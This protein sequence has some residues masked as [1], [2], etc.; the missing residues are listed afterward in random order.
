[1]AV[2]INSGLI[3]E[4]IREGSGSVDDFVVHWEER[5]VSGRQRV[6]RSRD[7]STIYRWLERG[8]PSNKDDVFGFAAAL[9]VDPVGIL[10]LDHEHLRSRFEKE[11]R[12]FQ[13]GHAGLSMLSAFWPIYMP[14]PNWPDNSLSQSFY[15]RNWHAEN[16]YHDPSNSQP[17]VFA[18]I[19]LSARTQAKSAPR[20]YHVAYK[21]TNAWDAMWRPYG[22]VVGVRRH[23]QLL[24][25]SGDFQRVTD[26]RSP[27]RV[28]FDTY[29]GPGPADFRI[30][31][32]HPFRLNIVCPS[33]AEG[34]VRFSA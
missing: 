6:G 27:D 30:A 25:E 33:S 32:I 21:R 9:D 12:L 31:S 11:R 2:P 1:M 16:F 14:G 3:M 26:S 15:A 19:V 7:R 23:V 34:C 20:V 5:L 17:N 4:L 18:N 29:F 10:S 13:A 8:L 22:T 28:S 24:S